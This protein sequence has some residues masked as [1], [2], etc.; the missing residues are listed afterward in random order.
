M[1]QKIGLEKL[2]ENILKVQIWVYFYLL[3]SI[4]SDVVERFLTPTNDSVPF[5]KI[6]KDEP[7]VLTWMLLY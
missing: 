7:N 1:E 4:C 3:D 2:L 5:F 6:R